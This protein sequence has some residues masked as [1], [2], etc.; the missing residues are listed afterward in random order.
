LQEGGK[1]TQCDFIDASIALWSV[2]SK[3][4]IGTCV[5]ALA[6]TAL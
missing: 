6:L 4:G 5:P 2:V 1:T 3:H